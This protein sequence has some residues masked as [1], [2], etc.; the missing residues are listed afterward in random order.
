MNTFRIAVVAAITVCASCGPV[1]DRVN[2]DLRSV[3]TAFENDEHGD[4]HSIIVI[5]NGVPVVER[6]YNGGDRRTLVD[7]RSAGKSV[8]SLL[9]G[10]ALDQG[11]IESLDD[12][13][14]KYWPDAGGSAIGP[15]RLADV[16]TMRTGLAADGNDPESPGYEDNLDA[17][18]DPLSFA[19]SV[20]GAEEPG[21]RY[22]YNSLAAYI[23][24]IVIERAVVSGLEDFAR[25]NLFE[26]LK[27]ERWDWQEDRAGQTKGQGNLFLTAPGFARIGELVL[28]GGTYNGRRVVS[29]E[30]IDES[31]KPRFDISDSDPYASGYGYYWYHQVYSLDDRPIEV[32]FASGNGGNKIYVIP[33]FGL[34]VSVMSRAYGQRHGQRRSH[35]IL[36]AIL[37]TQRRL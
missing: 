25:A 2:S 34:V 30:W 7:V 5:Q 31:L 8:T 17:A 1:E 36:K 35:D 22:R 14:S 10:I 20:P 37:A 26:P 33:E 3:L 18:D 24:G 15:V 11:A 12:P 29:S 21:T 4:L 13:V 23:A 28:N 27:I 6:Y 16:L 9:F 32:S 19:M